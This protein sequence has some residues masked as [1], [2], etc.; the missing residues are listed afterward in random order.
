MPGETTPHTT[1]R[2][3]ANHVTGVSSSK[4]VEMLGTL[5]DPTVAGVVTAF[6]ESAANCLVAEQFASV[7][8]VGWQVSETIAAHLHVKALTA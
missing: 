4:A 3:G 2:T 5:G 1:A 6:I 8:L 7:A